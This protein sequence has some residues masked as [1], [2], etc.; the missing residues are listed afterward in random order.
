MKRGIAGLFLTAAL[1]GLPA[2]AALP[3]SAAAAPKAD[4]S[5][6][7]AGYS[8]T[9]NAAVAA[10]NM[11]VPKLTCKGAA[12]SYAGQFQRVELND[13]THSLSAG[14]LTYCHGT[15]AVYKAEFVMPSGSGSVLIPAKITVH[16]RS[17]VWLQA[18]AGSVQSSA[19]IQVGKS[20]VHKSGK[21]TGLTNAYPYAESTA[22]PANTNGTPKLSGTLL[23]GDPVLP[24]P[25]VTSRVTF[26]KVEF[27]LRFFPGATGLVPVNW[28]SAAN[29]AKVLATTSTVTTANS[30]FSITY[31]P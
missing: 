4:T 26:S 14:I 20:I 8:S 3:A 17:K 21:G 7:Y 13:G 5:A 29:P 27:G 6:S 31:T 23:T 28:V 9:D 11:T 2:L 12:S 18:S 25:A 22:V 15:T 1:A 24:G 30:G 19:A 10:A 16:P